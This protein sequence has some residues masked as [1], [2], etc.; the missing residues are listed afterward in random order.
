MSHLNASFV[1]KHVTEQ[2][3]YTV[4]LSTG[5][6]RGSG[7]DERDAGVQLCLIGEHGAALLHY[8]SPVFDPQKLQQELEAISEV[9][10]AEHPI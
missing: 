2:T 3:V 8:V 1:Q 10:L 4:R 9:T 7:L 5:F 6:S